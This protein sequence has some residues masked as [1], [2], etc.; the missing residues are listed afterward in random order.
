MVHNEAADE[1]PMI[2]RIGLMVGMKFR[3]TRSESAYWY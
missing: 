2:C 1:N 3:N